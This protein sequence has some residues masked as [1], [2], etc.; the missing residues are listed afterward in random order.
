M[1]KNNEVK[2]KKELTWEEAVRVCKSIWSLVL[3]GKCKDKYEALDRLGLNFKY[4][5]NCPLCE[6]VEQR[7]KD[8]HTDCPLSIAFKSWCTVDGCDFE[9][10]PKKFAARVLNLPAKNPNG[11]D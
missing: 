9:D 7:S 8:C 4:S 3:S 2:M 11:E 6:Y 10:N 5:G 1:R